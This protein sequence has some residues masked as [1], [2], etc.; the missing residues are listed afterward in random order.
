MPPATTIYTHYLPSPVGTGG[1]SSDEVASAR[2]SRSAQPKSQAH[3]TRPPPFRNRLLYF[4]FCCQLRHRTKRVVTIVVT[5]LT[6]PYGRLQE[7][8]KDVER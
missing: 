7:L 6:P 2:P 5:P 3:V 1:P 4:A 8:G